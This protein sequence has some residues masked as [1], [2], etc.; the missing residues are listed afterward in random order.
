MNK[1]EKLIDTIS[2]SFK[3]IRKIL[4]KGATEEQ[5]KNLEHTINLPLP[6]TLKQLLRITNGD[7]KWGES[8]YAFVGYFLY[9]CERIIREIKRF[10]ENEF[11]FEP[12]SI[13]QK[14]MIK[15]TLYNSK[16][17]PFATDASGQFLCVD[18]DPDENGTYGQIIYLPCAEPEPVSVIAKDFDEYIDILIDK[19]K[20]DDS[21]I[22]DERSEWEDDDWEEWRE[23]EN[24]DYSRVEISF[25][26][27]KR[28]DWKDFAD[29]YNT[30]YGIEL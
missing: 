1:A 26:Y 12:D 21:C 22:Y 2:L 14:G 8:P 9:S 11:Q 16:R 10:K 19:L 4:P 13:Y 29:A 3:D 30:K 17:I 25:H 27:K 23:E 15:N 5:I 18:C 6:E 28:N 24:S 7:E 20:N